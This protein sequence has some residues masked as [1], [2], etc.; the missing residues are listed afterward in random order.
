MEEVGRRWVDLRIG[1]KASKLWY[2]AEKCRRQ[3]IA[4]KCWDWRRGGEGV[5]PVLMVKYSGGY[6]QL[7]VVKEWRAGVRQH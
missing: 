5:V 4:V 3:E 7:G 1:T 2:E 6:K